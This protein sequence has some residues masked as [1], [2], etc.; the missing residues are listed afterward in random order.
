M[1]NPTMLHQIYSAPIISTDTLR[2]DHLC[3]AF[4]SEA[5]RLGI[6]LP[7][8]TWQPAA[9][10][11]AHGMKGIC[12]DLPPRLQE[13][14]GDVIHELIEHLEWS[15]PAGCSIG[16][17]EGDGACFMWHLSMDAQ[18]E[19]IN[20]DPKGR[21]EAKL[22]E[23]PEHWLSAIV[24]GD[25]SSFDYYDDPADYQS[26]QQFCEEELSDGWS[27]TDCESESEFAWSHDASPYGVL[28][29]DV[30]Q[31]I[32]LRVRQNVTAIA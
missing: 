15:A 17:A 4:I 16:T 3:S 1:T 9:A 6:E 18:V 25:E 13:I 31:C 30:V 14:A 22:L 12:L 24:N 23:V 2:P 29:C 32:A 27:V 20:A 8:E 26:Y 10:I 11:A 19:A 5:D 21:W 28:A 7:R